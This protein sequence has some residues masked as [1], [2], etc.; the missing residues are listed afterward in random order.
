M[1][2]FT[3]SL[4]LMTASFVSAEV[5]YQKAPPAVQ[6]VLDAPLTPV[7]SV[8]PSRDY[9]LVEQS[10]MYPPIAE[11]SQPFLRLAGLR[12]NA[13]INALHRLPRLTKLSV[14]RLPD[15]GMVPLVMPLSVKPLQPRWSKDGSR[16]AFAG[17]SDTGIRLH[18]GSPSDGKVGMLNVRLNY[19]TDTP[20]HWGADNHTLLILMVPANR[21]AAPAEPTVPSGPSIQESSG[22]AGPVRTYEDMLRNPY[23]EKLFDYYCTSQLAWI[24]AATGRTTPLGAPA[25][26]DN[27]SVSPDGKHI[28]LVRVQKP[29]SY[30]HPF[31]SFPREVEVWD[32]HGKLEYKVASQPLADRVQ[33]EGVRTG[34]RSWVWQPS[35]PATLVW[36]E[37]LDGGDPERQAGF[38]DRLVSVKAPFQDKPAELIKLKH[39]FSGITFAEKSGLA[40]VRNYERNRRWSETV[41][42]DMDKPDQAPKEI[43][44]RNTQD[45]YN[46]PGQ[47]LTRDRGM[48]VQDGAV[49]LY[50]LG[51]T[52]QGDRPF[53]NRFFLD[54]RETSRLFRSPENA[55]ETLVAV[56]SD[57]G[58]RLIV[59]RESPREPPNYYIRDAAGAMKALTHYTD[60]TPQLRGITKQ[61]VTYKRN[62]GV[63]LSFTLYL[64]PD[65]KPGTRLP[66]VVW[67]YPREFGDAD[68]AGQ[69]SGSTQRFTSIYGM[70]HLF[71]LLQGYAVLD[72]AA[73]PVVGTP[74]KVNDTYVQQIVADAQA[75]ID[76]AVEMGV[77]DRERVGVGGHSYGAFM[78]ANL[79]AHCDLFK[80]GIARSGAYNRTLTPFGF[81]SERR[82]FWKAKEL[83]LNMSPFMYADK[84]KR[85]LLMIHGEADD[86]QGTFPI[87]SERMFHAIQGNGGKARLVM[88]PAEAHAYTARESIEHTLYE[89][90][91]WFDKYL[92]Q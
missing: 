61:L 47:T 35:A 12:I 59:R 69:V 18:V 36:A 43:W 2:R 64:P 81:Q 72:N 62:D 3:L 40:L 56:L 10:S 71:F 57:D 41:L 8:S 27:V 33:I 26:F 46:D 32:R 58:S 29:Y 49:L 30:L 77:T 86:N 70:S 73:M 17:R 38:R 28:L 19:T 74:A 83:Y 9:A 15:G 23:D 82:T 85:P 14:M 89:M 87:Q 63:A 11:V 6:S 7:L 1:K 13:K 60:P 16:F 31:T 22:K 21:G 52:P 67:A 45:R 66:T 79:L 54:T 34:P 39:R 75:A 80:A 92:K 68:T 20:F 51:A 5:N 50:G 90:I 25:I 91:S 65:Y 55:Y 44:S 78:T 53:L 88:L 37:A 48:I 84:I 4:L 24:D 76:K 42:L